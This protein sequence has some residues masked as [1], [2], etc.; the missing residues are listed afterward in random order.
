MSRLSD[1]A[2]AEALAERQGLPVTIEPRFK[3][4]GFGVWEGR[5]PDELQ[6]EDPAGYEAFYA[7]PVHKR[8]EGAEPLDQF[9]VR[10]V[11]AYQA[12]LQDYVGQHCLL[13]CHAG[14]IRAVIA[15]V[16]HAGLTGMYRIKVDYASI[17]RIRLT[18]RG[19]ILEFHNHYS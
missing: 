16:L 2:F 19:A 3:E 5:S 10:V 4:V 17:S 6:R 18:A 12:I 11:A 13:V 1:E 15:E 7:D 9:A 14:V 8:P